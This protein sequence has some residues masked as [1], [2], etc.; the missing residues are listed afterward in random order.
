[1]TVSPRVFG[2]LEEVVAAEG[3]VLGTSDWFLVDQRIVDGFADVT[4]DRQWIH[5]DPH[6]AA[7]GPFGTTIAHGYLTLALLPLLSQQIWAVADAASVVN[8]GLNRVRFHRPVPVGSR[9]RLTSTLQSTRR[10]RDALHVV[11]QERLHVE[12]QERPACSAETV[13][14]LSF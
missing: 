4:G 1:M 8:A 10:M 9:I 3:E 6:R 11:V 7:T 5:V 12:G 2:S 13:T 14:L